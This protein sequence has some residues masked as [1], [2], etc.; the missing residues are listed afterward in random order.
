MNPSSNSHIFDFKTIRPFLIPSTRTLKIVFQAKGPNL[1]ML[2]EIESLINWLSV[3]P[4][5]NS[6]IWTHQES[7]SK[8]E[9]WDEIELLNFNDQQFFNVLVRWQKVCTG[10]YYLPQ[11]IIFD[12][13]DGA[14]GMSFELGLGADI[15]IS[16]KQA[17]IEL[18]MPA[19]GRVSS[20]GGIGLL[21]T[22]VSQQFTRQWNLINGPIEREQLVTSGLIMQTYQSDDASTIIENILNN[23]CK[24]S[25]IA[26]IQTK[27]SLLEG[28]REK[29]ENL[30]DREHNF[31]SAAH[32]LRDWQEYL[33]AKRDTQNP[34]F[35]TALEI[36]KDLAACRQ[37]RQKETRQS[38]G[39]QIH[40][41]HPHS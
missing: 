12:Y 21:E 20:C 22:I 13:S 8:L 32:G 33:L 18:N 5:I 16:S 15:R 28:I 10:Q 35:K 26:R 29:I 6:V 37:E 41:L 25:P 27:R 36:S 34:K 3:H 19:R 2:E 1:L 9:D 17:H 40:T 4:E 39:A 23:I 24:Q 31:S 30:K 14:T 7:N 11:T 38:E